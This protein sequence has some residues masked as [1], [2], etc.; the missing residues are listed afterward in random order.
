MTN[1]KNTRLNEIQRKLVEEHYYLVDDVINSCFN[2][3]DKNIYTKYSVEDARQDA[4][5]ALCIAALEYEEDNKNGASF[6]SFASSC[7]RYYIL[8]VIRNDYAKCN[9]D[10]SWDELGERNTSSCCKSDDTEYVYQ[11]IYCES[12]VKDIKD[13]ANSNK[14]DSQPFQMFLLHYHNNI[15]IDDLARK[16]NVTRRTVYRYLDY[17][18][19]RLRAIYT[20]V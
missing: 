15:N 6:K 9:N 3:T 10:I 19:N 18:R 4:C 2:K 7:I 14:K 20:P 13:K 5:H 12:I 16:Y 11:K 1:E 17:A 8:E